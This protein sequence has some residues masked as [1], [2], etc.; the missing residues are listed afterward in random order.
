MLVSGAAT[1]ASEG[2]FGLPRSKLILRDGTP[3]VSKLSDAQ[4]GALAVRL[5]RS[6]PPPLP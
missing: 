5:C 1:D 2:E 3:N 6:R 4:V